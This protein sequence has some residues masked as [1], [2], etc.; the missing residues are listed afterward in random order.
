MKD[1]SGGY[2]MNKIRMGV[3][4]LGGIARNVH[5][6]GIKSSPDAQLTAICDINNKVLN[7]MGELH[8]IPA[9][10]RFD[11]HIDMLKCADVDAVSICTP[12]NAHF[13][14]AM[15]AVKYRKPYA[16]EKPVTMNYKEAVLLRDATVSSSIPNMVCFSYR[17]QPAARYARALIEQG[18]LGDIFHVY[19]QYFQAWATSEKLPL[20]WRFNKAIAGSGALGDLGSHLLDLVTFMTGRKYKKICGHLNTFIKERLLPDSD[21]YG[22]VDVDDFCH[23]LAEM[24]GNTAAVLEI[25]RNATGRGNYQRVEIYGSKGALV[26]SL[27]NEN[28]LE[29]CIGDVYTSAKDFHKIPI[30]AHYK[31]NQMQSFFDIINGKGD[32]LT[33]T[34]AD[35]CMIQG[36]LDILA[37]GKEQLIYVE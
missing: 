37:E 31:G 30:P 29:V 10:H 7:N 18:H 24:D 36:I 17:F 28:T 2:T 22:R 23:V 32:G 33:A 35:G 1:I 19:A 3:I 11:N 8:N 15:D 25:T 12:N 20:I 6:P 16:L 5:I 13:A 14:I 26:Y 9:T 4:G 21:E 27:N 34:I